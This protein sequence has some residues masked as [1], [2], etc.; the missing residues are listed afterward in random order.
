MK[1]FVELYLGWNELADLLAE[2]MVIGGHT[3]TH[4]LLSTLTLSE[5]ATEINGCMDILSE[6]L[7]LE[8]EIFAYPYGDYDS[9]TLDVLRHRG[10]S[11]AFANNGHVVCDRDRP[12]EVDRL[13]TN[14]VP[15]SPQAAPNEWSRKLGLRA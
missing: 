4:P 12:L 9:A 8:T 11:L 1:D 7:S 3:V 13:D 2:G 6:K 10:C 15:V 14:Y 5:Q